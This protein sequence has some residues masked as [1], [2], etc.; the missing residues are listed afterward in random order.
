MK[1]PDRLLWFAVTT[2]LAIRLA[3]LLLPSTPLTTRTLEPI[4]DAPEYVQLARNLTHH[5]LFSLDSRPPFR[6][7]IFRTPGYPLFLAI[8]FTLFG[9][10]LFWPI[11]LQLLISVATAWLTWQLTRELHL[12]PEAGVLATFLVAASPNLA[13]LATKLVTETLFTFLLIASLLLLNRFLT[14]R[15]WPSLIACGITLGLLILTRPIAT[16][17]P[18]VIALFL[19]LFLR[20]RRAGALSAPLVLLAATTVVVAPWIIRNG[21]K[22]SRFII[23]TVQEH[24]SYLYSGALVFAADKGIGLNEAR[25]SMMAEAQA[26]YGPLDSTDEASFWAA[27]GRVGWRHTLAKPLLALK[28]HVA[29]SAASLLMPVSIRPLLVTFGADPTQ[30]FE[31]HVAQKFIG[32][33]ARGRITSALSLAWQER[34]AQMPK[35][36]LVILILATVFNTGLLLLALFGI[37]LRRNRPLLWLLLPVG[38]FILVSGPV[39]EARFR[40]PVEPLLAI[41]AAAGVIAL[42]RSANP[43][44]PEKLSA[45]IRD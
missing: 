14:L 11:L 33:I 15:H 32:L 31:T 35:M 5:R 9:P 28:I 19:T 26:R 24:N 38:Y 23:S 27:L 44:Q 22:T 34:L 41:Y 43:W 4:A 40:A 7:D 20:E 18:L 13:F 30:A 37:I 16:Y 10:S 2:T 17:F 45:A 3:L 8:P 12:T 36:A 25:D 1:S 29:G 6:P 42:R 21:H 39:G